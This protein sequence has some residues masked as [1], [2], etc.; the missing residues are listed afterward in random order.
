LC[1]LQSWLSPPHHCWLGSP[2]S[3]SQRPEFKNEKVKTIKTQPLLQEYKLNS[4][5]IPPNPTHQK[6]INMLKKLF[7]ANLLPHLEFLSSNLP[8]V[9]LVL[10]T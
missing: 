5:I 3:H 8:L 1:W 2:H 6:R 10:S 7:L 4:N 9:F